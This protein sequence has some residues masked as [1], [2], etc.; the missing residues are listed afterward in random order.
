MKNWFW[1]KVGLFSLCLDQRKSFH[2]FLQ[3]LQWARILGLWVANLNSQ[4]KQVIF[5]LQSLT[6][7]SKGW[8][9]KRESEARDY[10]FEPTVNDPTDLLH[11]QAPQIWLPFHVKLLTW[12]VFAD[13]SHLK[14]IFELVQPFLQS[15][16]P[17]IKALGTWKWGINSS[18]ICWLI[19]LHSL[20]N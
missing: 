9:R 16:F 12:H 13:I 8:K 20:C 7:L 19:L 10:H 1:C 18:S 3:A 5:I 14:S 17:S 4:V 11:A 15:C 6:Y 2:V